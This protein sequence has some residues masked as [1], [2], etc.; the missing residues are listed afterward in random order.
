MRFSS[1]HTPFIYA[2]E[3]IMKAWRKH[4]ATKF[5]RKHPNMRITRKERA[6]FFTPEHVPTPSALLMAMF[7]RVGLPILHTAP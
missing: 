4:N 2:K 6:T 5:V 7:N 1:S 3:T